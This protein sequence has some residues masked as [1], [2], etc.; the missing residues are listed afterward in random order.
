M[1]DDVATLVERFR[2]M[3]ARDGG[4]LTLI[5]A[6]SSVIRVAYRPGAVA[7]DCTDG[8]CTLPQ[9][10]LQALMSETVA[11]QLPG[12]RVEVEVAP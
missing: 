3:V 4:A 2:R 6:D 5:S 9:T 11:R 10:E 1:T 7:P 8:T 12:L